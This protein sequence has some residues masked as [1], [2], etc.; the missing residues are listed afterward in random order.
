MKLTLVAVLLCIVSV[1]QLSAASSRDKRAGGDCLNGGVIRTSNNYV[2]DCPDPFYGEYCQKDERSNQACL[3]GG[4]LVADDNTL[5]CECRGTYFGLR[6]ESEC[7]RPFQLLSSG[8]N[9]VGCF[10]ILLSAKTWYDAPAAC[11]KAHPRARLAVLDTADKNNAVKAQLGTFSASSLMGNCNIYQVAPYGYSFWTAGARKIIKDCSSPFY[12]KSAQGSE[13]PV[14][15]QNFAPNE[16]SC[17]RN[18]PGHED[19]ESCLS[20]WGNVAYAWNDLSCDWLICS[21]CEIP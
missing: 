17:G 10:K 8:G 7:P 15:F 6:C 4:T 16:P 21:V 13:K 20:L 9:D 14:S 1:A 2:C 5:T 18:I 12:W 19:A 11:A 3:N